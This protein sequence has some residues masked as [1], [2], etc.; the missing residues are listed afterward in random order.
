VTAG[1]AISAEGLRKSFRKSSFDLK[2]DHVEAAPGSVLALLG[3]SGSGKS[4][5]LLLLGLLE[6]PDAGSVLLG[7][8]SVTTRDRSA[9]LKMAAVFQRPYLIKGS[10]GSNVAYGLRAHGVGSS[11]RAARVAAALARVGLDGYGDR[12]AL[13]LSGGE[14]QRVSLARAL[15]LE[16][17]VLLLDEPMASLDA[18]LKEQLTDDFASILR[19]EGVTVIWVTHDQDEAMVVADTVAIMNDGRIVTAGPADDV[20]GLPHDAWTAAFLGV[21]PPL[22]GTVLEIEHG[23]M[24]I[25]CCAARIAA[26]GSFPAGTPVEFSVRP[27]DVILARSE[28]GVSGLSARNRLEGTVVETNR[29]GSTLRVVLDVG[30]AL[31]ASSVSRSAAAELGLEPGRRVIAVFKATAVRVRQRSR[32]ATDSAH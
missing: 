10:V 9:R 20:M 30:G 32:V 22:E 15:V 17:R 14:A 5:L 19:N 2:I 27:E 31:I 23:L 28:I 21:E 12:S 13:S 26:I 24:W 8:E 16:P 1:L 6:E 3:P 25:G 7:G 4:T 11:E 18:L 29:R